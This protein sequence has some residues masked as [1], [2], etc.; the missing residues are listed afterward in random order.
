MKTSSCWCC[1]QVLT[2]LTTNTTDMAARLA[3]PICQCVDGFPAASSC[4][5]RY[6][7]GTGYWDMSVALLVISAVVV[8]MLAW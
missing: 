6:V 7:C 1:L 2:Q 3:S 8:C 4:T 5:A